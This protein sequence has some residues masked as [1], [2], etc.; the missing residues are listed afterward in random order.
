[1]IPRTSVEQVEEM[2]AAGA[3]GAVVTFPDEAGMRDFAH[4]YF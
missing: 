2:L 3:E 1:V 4:A